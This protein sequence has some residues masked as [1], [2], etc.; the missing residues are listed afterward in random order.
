MDKKRWWDYTWSTNIC[1]DSI[2]NKDIQSQEVD[3]KNTFTKFTQHISTK[4][5]KELKTNME[6]IHKKITMEKFDKTIKKLSKGC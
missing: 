1:I 2:A 4:E 6:N 3:F 5:Y